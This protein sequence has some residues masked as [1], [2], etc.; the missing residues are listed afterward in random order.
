M[1]AIPGGIEI[2]DLNGLDIE[3]RISA[4]SGMGWMMGGLLVIV[5][6]DLKI[7]GLINYLR[8]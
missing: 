5:L 1:L 7:A 2:H 3:E 6:Q 4:D 8:R